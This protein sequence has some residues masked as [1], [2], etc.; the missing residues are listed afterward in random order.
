M[1]NTPENKL[2]CRLLLAC[3]SVAIFLCVKPEKLFAAEKDPVKVLIVTGVD[4]PGHPWRTQAI[5]LRKALAGEKRIDVRLAEDIEILGTDLIFDYDVLL[6]NFK[7]YDP[8][9]REKAAKE[10]LLRFIREGGGLMF[11]HFTGGAFQ[12]WPEYRTIAARVW[13][14]E[15]RGHDPYQAFTVNVVKKDHAVMKGIQDFRITDELYTCMDGDREIEVL[16]EAKSSVDGKTYPMV[17]VFT[18]GKGRGFHTV[19]GHDGRAFE[20]PELGELLR[21]GALWCARREAVSASHSAKAASAETRL[22]EIS[23]N[24]PPGAKL[25]AYLDCGGEGKLEQGVKIVPGSTAKPYRFATGPDFDESLNAQVNVLFE[26]MQVDFTLEDLDRMKKYQLNIVWWDYDS[27]GRSQSIIAKTPDQSMV[28]ILR[29]GV[30]LPDFKES[31]LLPK[32]VTIPL[33]MAFVR[34]GKLLIS[35][36]NE[37]GPNAVVSEIWINQLP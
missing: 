8:L 9:K 20:S 13:N 1:M 14:P 28:K 3:F 2:S 4:Y 18:E 29:P 19:L 24:V 23:D 34:D 22:K 37:G 15:F 10:N 11:F 36:K 5:E 16:A 12:D 17:F 31:Q 33:P 7:N 6:L 35:V 25:L 27:S 32:T 30:S 26:S 21:R